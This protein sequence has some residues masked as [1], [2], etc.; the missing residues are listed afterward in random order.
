MSI[1][2][3]TETGGLGGLGGKL[4]GRRRLPKATP[5]HGVGS[6]WQ[7]SSSRAGQP[8]PGQGLWLHIWGPLA[9]WPG[10][11]WACHLLMEEG[12]VEGVSLVWLSWQSSRLPPTLILLCGLISELF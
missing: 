12:H 4:D 2:W 8:Q 11:A 9:L 3:D 10:G 6:K 5:T 7:G 1:G